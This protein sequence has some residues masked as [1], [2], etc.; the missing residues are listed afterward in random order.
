MGS[1][2]RGGGIKSGAIEGCALGFKPS[3]SPQTPRGVVSCGSCAQLQLWG[4]RQFDLNSEF[5]AKSRVQV[6]VPAFLPFLLSPPVQ[7]QGWVPSSTPPHVAATVVPHAALPSVAV[8]SCLP[9]LPWAVG[10]RLR[11]QPWSQGRRRGGGAPSM[12][13]Q[14]Q[15]G[16]SWGGHPVPSCR[17]VL[18][19]HGEPWFGSS[20]AL[21]ENARLALPA[22]WDSLMD[23]YLGLCVIFT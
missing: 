2:G 14:A 3:L 23:V 17:V 9:P 8:W 21:D 10:T 6:L 1:I 16:A 18:G 4:L 22:P 13:L 19:D 11:P 20:C 12:W 5:S 7:A 15:Q